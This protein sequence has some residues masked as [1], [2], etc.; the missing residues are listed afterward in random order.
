MTGYLSTH[1]PLWTCRD[2]V[3]KSFMCS[4]GVTTTILRPSKELRENRLMDGSEKLYRHNR[5]GEQ[6]S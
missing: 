2:W 5:K 4:V 1:S 6:P 3:K